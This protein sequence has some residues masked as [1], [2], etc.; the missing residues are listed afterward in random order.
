[1]GRSPSGEA[2]SRVESSRS[3]PATNPKPGVYMIQVWRKMLV[4][5]A[6]H[7][8][9][10]TKLQESQKCKLTKGS[11]IKGKPSHKIV[12]DGIPPHDV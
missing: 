6:L 8:Q 11:N 2:V 12:S 1:M 9:S 3:G 7:G 5:S 10:T 4:A